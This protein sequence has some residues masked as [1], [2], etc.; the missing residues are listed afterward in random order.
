[1]HA[2]ELYVPLSVKVTRECPEVART[3]RSSAQ[4]ARECGA[5][6]RSS[7]AVWYQQRAPTLGVR[8]SPM[9][10]FQKSFKRRLSRCQF[11]STIFRMSALR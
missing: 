5:G 11:S 9:S 6:M 3:L 7:T 2:R 4:G 1:L 8:F 10:L